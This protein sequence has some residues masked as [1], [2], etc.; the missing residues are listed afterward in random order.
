MCNV[1]SRN[2]ETPSGGT[3]G[4]DSVSGSGSTVTPD[5]DGTLLAQVQLGAGVWAIDVYLWATAAG[6]N[7]CSV[8]DGSTQFGRP[9][10]QP[11]GHPHSYRRRIG[12]TRT[13]TVR[14]ATP[15]AFVPGL[16]TCEIIATRL[17]A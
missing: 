17:D 6:D 15:S 4:S 10:A 13:I 12:S 11:D 9:Y 7:A 8:D 5:V 3:V 16:L 1:Q 2:P 14:T